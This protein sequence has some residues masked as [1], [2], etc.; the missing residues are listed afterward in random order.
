MKKIYIDVDGV[1]LSSWQVQAVH[2]AVELIDYVTSHFDCYWLTSYCRGDVRPVLKLLSKYYDKAT[3]HK[4]QSIKATH[5]RNQK[6]DAI[7]FESDF[8]WL[9]D[10][11][12]FSAQHELKMYNR[13]DRLIVVDLNRKDELQ[14]VIQLLK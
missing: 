5:W 14:R 6:T 12:S 8:Y 11:P 9:D 1:L 2:G 13:L 4:M 7:D 3:L 10:C